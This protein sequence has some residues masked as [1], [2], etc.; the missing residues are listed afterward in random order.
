[1]TGNFVTLGAAVA[2]GS[3]GTIAKLLALPVFCLTVIVV[4]CLTLLLPVGTRTSVLWMLGA[5]VALLSLGG[6]LALRWGPF[7]EPDSFQLIVTG[8]V[9]VSAMAIQN[10]VH[11]IHLGALPPSTLMTGS[12]T[13]IMIDLVD[14]VVVP[15]G[16]ASTQAR[17]RLRKLAP[18][19]L[20]FALGCGAAAVLSIAIGMWCFVVPPVV[21]LASAL[22][23]AS[24][25]D[26]A[27]LAGK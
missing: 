2:H 5:K 14:V 20:A 17:E 15:D 12:T 24:T 25:V 9:L 19:V 18:A 4:R 16:P 27:A 1:M 11:R 22:M 26:A 13:Q 10:A 7:N 3:S 8:M 21:G 6:L 23:H